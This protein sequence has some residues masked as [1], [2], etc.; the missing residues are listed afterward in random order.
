MTRNSETLTA[1]THGAG[2]STPGNGPSH[3][4]SAW[5]DENAHDTDDLDDRSAGV[6]VWCLAAV[7]VMCIA[8][9][10]WLIWRILP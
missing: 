4:P 8:V 10:A 2:E 6:A 1:T 9:A 3:R 7:L 5:A